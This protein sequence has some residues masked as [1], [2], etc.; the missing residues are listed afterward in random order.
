MVVELHGNFLLQRWDDDE[1]PRFAPTVSWRRRE[2]QRHGLRSGGVAAMGSGGLASRNTN[3][4]I[5]AVISPA[6]LLRMQ[7]SVG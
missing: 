1:T 2:P 3:P 4:S 7:D 5:D 6:G